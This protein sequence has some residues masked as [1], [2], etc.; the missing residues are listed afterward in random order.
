MARLEHAAWFIGIPRDRGHGSVTI[1]VHGNG[2]VRYALTDEVDV[3]VAHTSIEKQIRLHAAAGADEIVPFT[4]RPPAGGA[5][6]TSRSSSPQ[7]SA[8]RCGSAAIGFSPL[9]R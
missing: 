9:T 4:P 6:R 8:S 3:R 1:D 2:V 7:C 5:A